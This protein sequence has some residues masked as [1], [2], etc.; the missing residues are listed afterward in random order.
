MVEFIIDVTVYPDRLMEFF[1]T[2]DSLVIQFRKEPACLHYDYCFDKT[3]PNHCIIEAGWQ[4]LE[5][6]NN[7]L[8]NINFTILL[9]AIDLLC[10]DNQMKIKFGEQEWGME[11]IKQIRENV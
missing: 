7:H 3:N 8:R 10:R 4:N 11:Y 6:F 1:Q 5:E 9:G 2:L